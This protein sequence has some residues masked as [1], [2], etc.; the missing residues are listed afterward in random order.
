MALVAAV[1]LRATQ[2]TI[3]LR[4]F[5]PVG[6]AAYL[7]LSS[8]ALGHVGPSLS[9]LVSH[10]WLR[11]FVPQL[12]EL[13]QGD[14]SLQRLGI[15][16]ADLRQ[17]PTVV[18]QVAAMQKPRDPRWRA[19]RGRAYVFGEGSVVVGGAPTLRDQL[20]LD[21]DCCQTVVGY[22]S[23]SAAA[24]LMVDTNS[25]HLGTLLPMD[26]R[27]EPLALV[28]DW[29]PAWWSYV[30]APLVSRNDR[31]VEPA[32]AQ[33]NPALIASD[34]NLSVIA[35]EVVAELAVAWLAGSSRQPHD[36][37]DALSVRLPQVVGDAMV[38]LATS[39]S[40]PSS[41]PTFVLAWQQ[42]LPVA[43]WDE[44]VNAIA[45]QLRQ[46]QRSLVLPDGSAAVEVVGDL[47]SVRWQS[48]PELSAGV[49]AQGIET[50]AVARQGRMAAVSNDPSA[51]ARALS[52]S[53]VGASAVACAPRTGPWVLLRSGVL[54]DLM[55]Y[56]GLPDQPNASLMVAPD[57][58]GGVRGCW[59]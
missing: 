54:K 39:Q 17:P 4:Q 40:S 49:F 24:Q 29:Q 35:H 26:L 9:Q 22:V 36:L 3:N 50:F 5:A 37:A 16:W 33:P 55:G 42:A 1:F 8:P 6:S 45:A 43:S 19:L 58:G 13:V 30:V 52:R 14:P 51:L 2:S 15:V 56:W 48:V 12:A 47:G 46:S 7:E 53:S 28:V 23:A 27:G 21:G 38:D 11:Q 31:R 34:P 41:T 32:P 59:Q 20:N 57:D 10:P 25:V 44:T 18:A